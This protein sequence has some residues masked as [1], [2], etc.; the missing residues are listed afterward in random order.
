MDD[1]IN[2]LQQR[3]SALESTIN[4]M[5][6]EVK[7]SRKRRFPSKLQSVTM[8]SLSRALCVSTLDP[9]KEGRVKFY[10]PILHNPDT[11]LDSLPFARPISSFGGFDDCGLAWVPP[12]GSTLAIIF[13][14]G[15]RSAPFYIGTTWHRN[16]GPGGNLLGY[17]IREFSDVY[18]GHRK[19]YLVGLDDES[20]VLPPFNT[21]NYNGKD[22][23]SEREFI[24]D[25]EEQRRMTYPNIYGFKTLKSTCLN[26]LMAML[27]VTVKGNDLNS[28]LV[29][30]AGG[31]VLRM[32]ICIMVDNTHIRVAEWL[33][34]MLVNALQKKLFRRAWPDPQNLF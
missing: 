31:C 25:P 20:Q 4:E 3:I 28:C 24:I 16:R 6:I 21:E 22:L 5:A 13:E 9:M 34:L 7:A 32:I 18:A 27:S 33:D 11:P 10:H 30:A 23:E 2:S 8:P 19:G 14:N 26:W 29:A 12:A 1:Y 17:P 15:E